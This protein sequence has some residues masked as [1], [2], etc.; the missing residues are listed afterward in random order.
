[1]FSLNVEGLLGW[2]HI[3]SMNVGQKSILWSPLLG[4]TPA[5]NYREGPKLLLDSYQK[6]WFKIIF[7]IGLKLFKLWSILF[8]YIS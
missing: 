5:R 4:F 8:A 1:V 6:V 7:Q 2:P 3:F